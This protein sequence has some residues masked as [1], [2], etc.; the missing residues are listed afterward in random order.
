MFE[1]RQHSRADASGFGELWLGEAGEIAEVGRVALARGDFDHRVSRDFEHVEDWGE[2]VDVRGA[3]PLFPLPDG[4]HSDTG[5]ASEVL[6]GD[7]CSTPG[8]AQPLELVAVKAPQDAAAHWP[9]WSVEHM[10][11]C[12]D[13]ALG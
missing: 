11:Q 3:L 13:A 1:H 7:A 4:G 6:G 9:L 10:G 12:W 2:L 5:E 8:E